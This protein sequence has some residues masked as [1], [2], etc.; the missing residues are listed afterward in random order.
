[1]Y[2]RKYNRRQNTEDLFINT[3][4]YIKLCYNL[5]LTNIWQNRFHVDIRSKQRPTIVEDYRLS[6]RLWYRV[7]EATLLERK[8]KSRDSDL[9]CLSPSFCACS[10]NRDVC[11]IASFDDAVRETTRPNKLNPQIFLAVH[12]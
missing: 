10:R 9:P 2:S 11:Q 5:Y 1:M 3:K 6:Q 4:K 12:T 7:Q 8:R